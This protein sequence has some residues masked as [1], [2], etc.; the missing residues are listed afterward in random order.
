MV[1]AK[2]FVG[3]A[4]ACWAVLG[5]VSIA[6]AQAQERRQDRRD[7]RRGATVQVPERRTTEVQDRDG[8]ASKPL[9]AKDILGAKVSIKGDTSVGTVDDIVFDRDGYVEYLLVNKDGKY[10]VVPWQAAKFN[11][12]QRVATV[13]ITQEK[14]RQVPTY[15]QGNWPNF[16]DQT[17][18]TQVYGYYG[19]RPGQERRLERREG[20]RR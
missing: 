15:T 16:Y 18:R 20:I 3:V 4:V 12:G 10:V 7:E 19:L 5:A 2:Q 14:F 6:S 11:A 1:R 13:N 8:R 9:R 17:Y